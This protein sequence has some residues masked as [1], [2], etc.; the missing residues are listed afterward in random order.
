MEEEQG[1]ERCGRRCRRRRT[2]VCGFRA[3]A[4]GTV[5][6]RLCVCVCNSNGRF[7]PLPPC[8]LRCLFQA[9]TALLISALSLFRSLSLSLSHSLSLSLSHAP[10]LVVLGL[11]EAAL[12]LAQLADLVSAHLGPQ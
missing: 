11:Q 9:T 2:W 10:G 8:S 1:G 3:V 12:R 7:L 6:A 5:G 4:A